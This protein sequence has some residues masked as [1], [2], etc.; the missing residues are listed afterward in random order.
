MTR[1]LALLICT[2]VAFA[3]TLHAA[4]RAADACGDRHEAVRALVNE[5][6][7]ALRWVRP[8]AAREAAERARAYAEAHEVDSLGSYITMTLAWLRLREGDWSAASV[9]EERLTGERTVNDLLARTMLAERAVRLGIPDAADRLA[10]LAPLADRTHEL[11]R[12]EPVLEL[13]I[14]AALMLGE[15][16]PVAGIARAA[17]LVA[18][19]GSPRPGGGRLAGWARVA[20]LDT[21][22]GNLA[23]APHAAMRAGDW[24][25]AADAFGAVGW[26]YDR[27]LFLSLLDDAA[28][29]REALETARRLGA[30]PL[31]DRVGRRLRELGLVIPHGRR[32]STRANPAGLT[33]RQVEVLRL[34]GEG[35]TTVEIAGRLVLSPRT[36]EHHVEAALAKLAA[37]TRRAAVRRAGELGVLSS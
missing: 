18:Q 9:A 30:A 2:L 29:L 19:P 32:E 36:V 4:H 15:P 11:Q 5:A 8:A 35:L 14:E 37:P 6:W 34:V 3:A 10:E 27:A 1:H 31:A 33:E 24:S 20:G 17:A 12:I 22:I 21:G 23:P 26:V 16:M 25:A 28:A 13:Q 7:T